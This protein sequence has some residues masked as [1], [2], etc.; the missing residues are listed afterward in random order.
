MKSFI[1]LI[2]GFAGIVPIFAQAA[3]ITREYRSARYLGMGDAGV[4]LAEGHDALFYNPAGIAGV[5]ELINEVVLV[6]PQLEASANAR[7]LYNQISDNKSA[8]DILRSIEGEPQYVAVQ[9]YTGLV[10]RRSA[11]GVYERAQAGLFLGTDP[12]KGMLVAS[13]DVLARAGVHAA[14]GQS[15]WGNSLLVGL[16]LKFGQKNEGHINIDALTAEEQMKG[17]SPSTALAKYVRRGNG[18]GADLGIIYSL[19]DKSQSRFGLVLRNMG[20]MKYRWSVPGTAV[21]PTP[22]KQSLDVGFSIVPQT[23]KSSASL[24][25]DFRDALNANKESV[26]KRIHL[27]TRLS[28]KGVFGFMAGLN[29]GYPTYGAFI[30]AK[31]LRVEAGAYSEELGENPGDMRG[32]RIYARLI[33]GWTQ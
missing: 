8:I 25:V 19:S 28:F 32:K 9:N 12:V 14:F 31:I 29:Q 20:D 6:S 27:G 17:L 22:D 26:Y 15:F 3:E 24:A 33:V 7:D 13:A 18:V 5:K 30:N 2:F 23:K 1:N 21:G 4:S 16:N 10:F 11:L